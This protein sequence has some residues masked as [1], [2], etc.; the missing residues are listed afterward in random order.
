VGVGR[1]YRYFAGPVQWPFGAGI[2]Y[3]SFTVDPLSRPLS[4]PLRLRTTGSPAAVA[5]PPLVFNVSNT[6]AWD[7]DEVVQL[8]LRPQGPLPAQPASRL[9]RRRVH[10]AA[11]ESVTVSFN[12]SAAD[13]TL[14]DAATGDR[15]STPGAFLLS[16]STDGCATT[17]LDVPV[18]LEGE[19]A[20]VE[21]FPGRA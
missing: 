10:L 17:V 21:R 14:V 1:G 5:L 13:L 4:S 11:G 2:S 12:V 16:A 6:G 9:I 15:V 3:T 19:E 20:V 18:L 7:G 8:Y